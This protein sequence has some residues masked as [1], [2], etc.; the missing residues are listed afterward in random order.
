M[1]RHHPAFGAPFLSE[2]CVIDVGTKSFISDD[3][4]PGTANPRHMDTE[5]EGPM[6]DGVDLL[7]GVLLLFLLGFEF[8]IFPA[9][10]FKVPVGQL[11]GVFGI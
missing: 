11:A 4:Y 7:F 3:S 2:Q 9:F 8:G 1:W 10:E 6:A 5:Y